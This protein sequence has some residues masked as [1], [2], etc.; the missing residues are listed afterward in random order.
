MSSKKV[1]CNGSIELQ[2]VLQV[3]EALHKNV[4][5][6]AKDFW[7]ENDVKF[8]LSPL[9]PDL[10]TASL[11]D[12]YFKSSQYAQVDPHIFSIAWLGFDCLDKIKVYCTGGTEF[13]KVIRQIEK[14]GI[15]CPD[16]AFWTNKDVVFIS[17][18]LPNTI[19][20]YWK[21]Y[22]CDYVRT[23]EAIEVNPHQFSVIWLGYD[24]LEQVENEETKS[25]ESEQHEN[26]VLVK[27]ATIKTF[28]I[29]L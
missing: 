21:H 12:G 3:I 13:A 7:M 23:E 8:G 26:D 19:N 11:T 16:S 5:I 18:C 24:C 20:Y 9:T 6:V 22:Y 2:R 25:L 29:K 1:Y 15:I 28:K 17:S 4:T 10:I 27:S 14:T